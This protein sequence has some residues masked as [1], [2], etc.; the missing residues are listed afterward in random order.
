MFGVIL[1]LGILNLP[2][3]R[4]LIEGEAAETGFK[5]LALA[6]LL[7]PDDNNISRWAASA[8]IALAPFSPHELHMPQRISA[9]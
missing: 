8:V 7:S 1:Q 3:L 9:I 5:T 6:S 4:V 2:Y